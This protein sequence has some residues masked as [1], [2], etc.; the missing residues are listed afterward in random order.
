MLQLLICGGCGNEQALSITSSQAADDSCTSDRA[1][2]DR[3]H[4][5]QFCFEDAVEVLGRAYCDERVGV[6]K[7]REDADSGTWSVLALVG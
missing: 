2:A 3:D 7:R 5:L 1:V 6:C 4:I